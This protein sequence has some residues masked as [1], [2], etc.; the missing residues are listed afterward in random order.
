MAAPPR[1]QGGGAMD[2][3][4]GLGCVDRGDLGA[5]GSVEVTAT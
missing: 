3:G 5:H 1:W 4:P 2:L